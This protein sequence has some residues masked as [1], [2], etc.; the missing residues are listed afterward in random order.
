MAYVGPSIFAKISAIRRV[1]NPM[2]MT[3]DAKIPSYDA[4]NARGPK[5]CPLAPLTRIMFPCTAPIPY[6]KGTKVGTILSKV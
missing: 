6:S 2:E 5:S 1:F 4:K 3:E